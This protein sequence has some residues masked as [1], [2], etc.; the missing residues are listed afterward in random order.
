M[1]G[2]ELFLFLALTRL[3]IEISVVIF[4]PGLVR[5]ISQ[6]NCVF[7]EWSCLILYQVLN[8]YILTK[9]VHLCNEITSPWLERR[10]ILL[11][12][13]SQGIQSYYLNTHYV[14]LKFSI[15]VTIAHP[16]RKPTNRLSCQTLLVKPQKKKKCWNDWPQESRRNIASSSLR[17]HLFVGD[18]LFTLSLHIIFLLC[19]NFPF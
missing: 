11:K 12:L 7:C 18:Y 6:F 2:W 5:M 8:D 4:L 10:N 16:S 17:Y 13:F 9:Q 15:F 3:S 19:L 14:N 1:C